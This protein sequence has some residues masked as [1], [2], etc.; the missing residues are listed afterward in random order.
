MSADT[1]RVVIIKPSKYDERGRVERFRRGFMPNSTLA[2]LRSMT[3]VEFEGTTIEAVGIDEYIQ[4]DMGYLDLLRKGQSPTLLA[5][6]GVQSHQYQRA[7]DL[8]ALARSRGVEHCVIGG[9]HPMTCDTTM[10]QGRGV[11][12]ALAEAELVWPAILRAAIGGGLQPVYGESERW[13]QTLDPPVLIPPGARD[14]RRYLVPMLGIYPARGCPF[15]C[16]FCSVIKIA[17][18]RVRSQ[19]VETT[20]QSLLAAQRAGVKLIMFTSDNFNK[21]PEAAELLRAM[22]D[23][24]LTLPFF[25]QCDTQIV[26]DEGLVELL[27]RAGCCQMFV[28]VESFDRAILVGAR[29]FQNKP[30]HYGEIVRLCTQYGISTHFANIIGFPEQGEDGILEHLSLLRKLRPLVASFYILTPIPGTEQYDEFRAKGLIT[31]KNLDRFDTSCLVWQHPKLTN[32][33]LVDLMYRCYREFFALPDVVTNILNRAWRDIRLSIRGLAFGYALFCRIAAH[34]RMHPMSGGIG[35][36]FLDAA[37]DYSELRR[38]HFG[39]DLLPLPASLSTPIDRGVDK[40]DASAFLAGARASGG[41]AL[42]PA[43]L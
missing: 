33:Q 2:F 43:A 28:G 42:N 26:R 35:R 3:P 34:R 30:A 41:P 20:V 17:G 9:P 25:V 8:A 38:K 37:S 12:F 19:A 15:T 16:N 5:L 4:T 21:Y 22:I 14:A 39:F 23:A 36:V 32:S 18:K 31:E 27:G 11:S 1:L 7:L 29:K 6:A 24:K 40:P 13:Q 10:V